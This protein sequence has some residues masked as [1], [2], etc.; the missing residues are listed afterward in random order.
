MKKSI[1]NDPD[2]PAYGKVAKRSAS[3]AAR[4]DGRVKVTVNPEL[5]ALSG[6]VLFPEKVAKANEIVA[7][8]GV[9]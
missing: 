9:K 1:V 3:R 5:D 7:R 6:K 2:S 4:G 8:L